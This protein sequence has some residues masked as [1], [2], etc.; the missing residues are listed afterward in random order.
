MKNGDELKEHA[1]DDLQMSQSNANHSSENVAQPVVTDSICKLSSDS[2]IDSLSTD[3]IQDGCGIENNQ[4]NLE[5]NNSINEQDDRRDNVLCSSE[6]ASNYENQSFPRATKQ[7][8]SQIDYLPT[9]DNEWLSGK[10]LG[11]A[12]Q[13]T[14]KYWHH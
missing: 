14:G 8:N 12:G 9:D 5:N 10:V 7:K 13:A 3:N 2:E 4:L 11:Q 6:N 1:S